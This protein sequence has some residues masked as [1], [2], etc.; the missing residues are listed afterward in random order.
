MT[1]SPTPVLL[2]VLRTAYILRCFPF[3]QEKERH[4]E[5]VIIPI[6]HILHSAEITQIIKRTPSIHRDYYYLNELSPFSIDEA[7]PPPIRQAKHS[8]K[9]QYGGGPRIRMR[10]PA[11]VL[12][13][14]DR[15]K[16]LSLRKEKKASKQE[17]GS[18]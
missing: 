6:L 13:R 1:P 5:Q 11:L 15:S 3:S 14:L 8:T 12:H 2:N 17:R 16:D 18:I 9:K 7:V 4:I 10:D